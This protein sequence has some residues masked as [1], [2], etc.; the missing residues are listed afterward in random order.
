M[1]RLGKGRSFGEWP[2]GWRLW[3]GLS[4]LR[5]ELAMF[6]KSEFWGLGCNEN[7]RLGSLG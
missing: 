3:I 2:R 5:G 1:G 6:F 7:S 4:A